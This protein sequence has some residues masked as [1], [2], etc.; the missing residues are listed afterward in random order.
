MYLSFSGFKKM[1]ECA[2]SYWNGYVNKT[3]IEG[4]VDDRLGSIFGSVIGAV[5]EDFYNMRL[6]KAPEPRAAV[7]ARVE[8]NLTKVLH[9]ET[10]TTSEWRKAGVLLWRGDGEGQSPK[11]LYADRAELE[12]DIRDAVGRGIS[13]IKHDRLLG[14]RADAEVKLDYTVKGHKLG[15]RADFIIKRVRFHDLCIIDGKGSKWRDKYVDLRQLLWYGMLY[16]LRTGEVPDKLG[17]L[18]W[19]FSPPESLD[20]MDFSPEDLDEMLATV[21]ATIK[22]IGELKASLPASPSFEAARKVFMPIADTK[23]KRE[24]KEQA[25]RFCVYATEAV[26]PGGLKVA[27]KFQP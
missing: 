11:G 2:Y 13:A 19:K 25:C 4:V 23:A 9:E 27:K 21:L 5:F 26:C 22:K 18:F 15:G 12:A 6:W 1:D 24:A 20:W 8:P 14:P 10:T 7:Y 3:K 17:Y 16:K